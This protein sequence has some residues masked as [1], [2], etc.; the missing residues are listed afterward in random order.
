MQ[1]QVRTDRTIAQTKAKIH[2]KLQFFGMWL[3][4]HPRSSPDYWTHR[5]PVKAFR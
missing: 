5:F 1:K 4:S 2:A 3:A